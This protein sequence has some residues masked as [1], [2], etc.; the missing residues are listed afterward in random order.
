LF[1]CF[2]Y[3]TARNQPF[4]G[5]SMVGNGEVEHRFKINFGYYF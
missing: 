4:I 2:D 1:T 5:G 3:V